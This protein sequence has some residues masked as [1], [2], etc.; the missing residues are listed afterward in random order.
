LKYHQ[1][2]LAGW[3][4]GWLVGWL[5]GRL[6]VWLSGWLAGWLAGWSAGGL[7]VD[8]RCSRLRDE[9]AVSGAGH[10]LGIR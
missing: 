7:E 1:C 6:A 5:A 2:W 9:I 8:A 4:A 3:L 10:R